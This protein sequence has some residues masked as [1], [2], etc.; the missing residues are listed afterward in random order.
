MEEDAAASSSRLG[1]A[2]G[3]C[4]SIS[5]S[6]LGIGTPRSIDMDDFLHLAE[7]GGIGLGE[8]GD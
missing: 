2:F 4:E 3:A 5:E 1:R 8:G 7:V 6:Y